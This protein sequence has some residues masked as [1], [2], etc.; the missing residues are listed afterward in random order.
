MV[1]L[2]RRRSPPEK[3]PPLS[4][5]PPDTISRSA[6]FSIMAPMQQPLGGGR[7]N[8]NGKGASVSSCDS[9]IHELPRGKKGRFQEHNHS[10]SQEDQFDSG[11]GNSTDRNEHV[12][13]HHLHRRRPSNAT[14]TEDITNSSEAG[15]VHQR[16]SDG[17][18]DA[19]SISA[20]QH[21]VATD[22]GLQG[23]EVQLYAGAGPTGTHPHGGVATTG[24]GRYPAQVAQVAHLDDCTPAV[25]R[26]LALLGVKSAGGESTTIGHAHKVRGPRGAPTQ[27]EDWEQK[28]DALQQLDRLLTPE[29]L[30]SIL[31]A[32]S[33]S[34]FF[35]TR[36]KY[37]TASPLKSTLYQFA[38]AGLSFLSLL[39]I[40][41]SIV[42]WVFVFVGTR[43]CQ[44]RIGNEKY[45]LRLG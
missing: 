19:A 22:A 20:I 14:A 3:S 29:K 5:A 27:C 32:V 25:R 12:S 34:G 33:F 40:V 28:V 45:R 2:T 6:T 21:R 37:D 41:H 43:Q 16:L 1:W 24:G 8:T 9:E 44:L 31:P 7:G 36:A 35:S 39:H 10:T 42:V 30:P 13:P 23:I 4:H 18:S 17:D 38:C 11:G 26:A 15:A